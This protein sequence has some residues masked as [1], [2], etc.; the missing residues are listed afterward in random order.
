MKQK[1][2]LGIETKTR[3]K[4]LKHGTEDNGQQNSRS[5]AHEIPHAHPDTLYRT[6]QYYRIVY[7]M[8]RYLHLKTEDSKQLY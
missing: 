8:P 7:N 4:K 2:N 5:T 1:Q 6:A 3:E